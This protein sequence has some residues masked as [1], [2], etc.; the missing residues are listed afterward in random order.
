M[1]LIN[2]NTEQIHITDY[3]DI[4]FKELKETPTKLYITLE[5]LADLKEYLE[6][7]FLDELNVYH[8]C[9]IITNEKI[10]ETKFA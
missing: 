8:N 9:K 5:D 10:K 7:S 2:N 1:K 3:L 6:L 4:K